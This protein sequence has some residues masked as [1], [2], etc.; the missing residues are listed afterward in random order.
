MSDLVKRTLEM[1]ASLRGLSLPPEER[2]GLFS[3]EIF[4]TPP[5]ALLSF[6]VDKIKEYVFA[7]SRPLEVKGASDIL[8][9]IT[10]EGSSEGLYKWLEDLAIPKENIIFAGGGSGLILLPASKADEVRKKIE[11]GYREET[12]TATCTAVYELFYPQELIYGKEMGVEIPECEGRYFDKEYAEKKKNGEEIPFGKIVKLL[13]FKLRRRKEEKALDELSQAIYHPYLRRCTSCGCFPASEKDDDDFLCESCSHKRE[14]AREERERARGW[15]KEA[16]DLDGIV[17]FGEEMD[18]LA[19]IY[20]DICETGSLLEKAETM[21]DLKLLSRAIREAVKGTIQEIVKEY[22]LQG[23]YQSPVVGGDDIVFLVA[24]RYTLNVVDALRKKLEAN[25]QREGDKLE[26][27]SEEVRM[28]LKRLRLTIGFVVA[29]HTFPISYLFQYAQALLRNA[30]MSY[31]QGIIKEE[32]R[33]DWIDFLVLKAGSPLNI[34]I[35]RI[36]EEERK[37][38]IAHQ[39]YYYLTRCPYKADDFERLCENIRLIKENKI[40]S[41]Q[42]HSILQLLNDYPFSARINIIYQVLRN[43]KKWR[44]VLQGILG[45]DDFGKWA[46]FFI[47][48]KNDNFYTGFVDLMELYKLEKG[49]GRWS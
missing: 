46:D 20:A 44:P 30:K 43:E 47:Y 6:D 23:R 19:F 42:L 1:E 37:R 29:P 48:K 8:E 34:D 3:K 12:K 49:A 5:L 10:D 40:P 45:T 31:Y 7:T 28:E 26:G 15:E 32:K 2:E 16:M 36:R 33:V 25:L 27:V 41:S 17:K 39:T 21:D 9:S 13:S 18:D 24:S 11:D 38:E 14:V 4:P 35:E 22:K